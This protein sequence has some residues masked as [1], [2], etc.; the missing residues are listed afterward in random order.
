MK[1]NKVTTHSLTYW[2]TY[3]LTHSLTHLPTESLTHLLTHSGTECGIAF[4]NFKQ[5]Q[6][7]DEVECYKVAYQVK[8]M[9]V[10]SVN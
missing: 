2:L 4:T 1:C 7:G 3:L 5:F 10:E 9:V 8:E 6:E